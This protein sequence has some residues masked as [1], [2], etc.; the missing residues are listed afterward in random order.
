M[1][2]RKNVSYP[3][4][5]LIGYRFRRWCRK[6]YAAFASLS[7]AVT[8][9]CLAAHV[10]ERFQTK[11]ATLHRSG[12]P[13]TTDRSAIDEETADTSQTIFSKW[14]EG[15]GCGYPALA[16]ISLCVYDT[17]DACRFSPSCLFVILHKKAEDSRFQAGQSSAFLWA[18]SAFRKKTFPDFPNQTGHFLCLIK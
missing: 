13:A 11:Y 10:S 4:S 3:S 6:G 8:I 15:N 7:R 1:N 5:R 2:T 9:G 12:L 16:A 14:I 17:A 18:L